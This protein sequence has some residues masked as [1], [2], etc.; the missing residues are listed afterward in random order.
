MKCMICGGQTPPSAKL[1]LPCRAALR[2]ARDD[3]ISELLP[4][5]RRREAFAYSNSPDI[6][7]VARRGPVQRHEGRRRESRP[8][9]DFRRRLSSAQLHAAAVVAFVLAAGLLTYV[10]TRE[11]QRERSVPA[12]VAAPAQPSDPRVLLPSVS[13]STLLDSARAADLPVSTPIVAPAQDSDVAVADVRPAPPPPERR[14]SRAARPKPL[15]PTPPPEP[16]ATPAPVEPPVVVMA[17]PPIPTPTPK[18]APPPDRGQL[19]V[20]ALAQCG[21]NFFS[22]TLCEHRARA[23]YCEGLWGQHPQCPAGVTNDHGQ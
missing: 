9:H 4:L 16:I 10:T 1:C 19:L 12:A 11:F 2:R 7:R 20:A 21:G 23:R 13:P 6:G 15:A 8:S 14:P 17:A 5:P 18:V 22:R 3:T